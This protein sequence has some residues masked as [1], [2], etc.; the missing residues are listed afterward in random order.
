MEVFM[1]Q[2]TR[3]EPDFRVLLV[4]T[5]LP[6]LQPPPTRDYFRGLV[7]FINRG[8]R[9]ALRKKLPSPTDGVPEQWHRFARRLHSAITG[10]GELLPARWADVASPGKGDWLKALVYGTKHKEMW[11]LFVIAWAAATNEWTSTDEEVDRAA[12]I[13]GYHAEKQLQ[14]FLQADD[15]PVHDGRYAWR[16]EL[17]GYSK[18]AQND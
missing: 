4:N 9:F 13:E 15:G 3:I 17:E 16:E 18:G 10:G 11:P 14:S 2:E 6:F 1:S 5:A 8:N 12:R 7:R